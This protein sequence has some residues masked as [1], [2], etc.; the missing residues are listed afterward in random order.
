VGSYIQRPKFELYDLVADP[1]EA[2]NLAEVPE[3]Q[4]ELKEL[5]S[6]LQAFQKATGD[7]WILKW[8]HE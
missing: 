1:A 3:M 6:Q 4:Q 8:E 7:P 5:I 2:K